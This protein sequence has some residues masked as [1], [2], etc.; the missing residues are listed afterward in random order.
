MGIAID[1]VQI[2]RNYSG[3]PVSPSEMSIPRV[4]DRAANVIGNS[5][6]PINFATV[7]RAKNGSGPFLRAVC[8]MECRLA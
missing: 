2:L 5:Y 7:C 8:T 1:V 6:S 3:M 4:N